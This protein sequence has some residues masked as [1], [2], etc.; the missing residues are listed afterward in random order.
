[1]VQFTDIQ[2]WRLSGD[3]LSDGDEALCSASL[4]YWLILKSLV[5]YS[6]SQ[7][8]P[9]PAVFRHFPQTVGNF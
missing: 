8:V 6:V 5:V 1:M 3:D 9:P 2:H 4:L 7:K